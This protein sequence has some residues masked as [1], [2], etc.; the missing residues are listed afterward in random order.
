MQALSRPPYFMP[1][2]CP[3]IR[4]KLS[5]NVDDIP[6]SRSLSLNTVKGL[7]R[8]QCWWLCFRSFILE[9]KRNVSASTS[10]TS[11]S[12]WFSNFSFIYLFM[13]LENNGL[14]NVFFFLWKPNLIAADGRNRFDFLHK[15]LLLLISIKSGRHLDRAFYI[16]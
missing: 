16:F 7:V 10:F 13:S 14:Y 9:N 6:W 8:G 2:R 1:D 5:Y 15:L 4:L 12:N 3:L 11:L